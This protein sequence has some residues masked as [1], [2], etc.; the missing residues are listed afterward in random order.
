MRRTGFSQLR[1]LLAIDQTALGSL[2]ARRFAF[3]STAGNNSRA[4]RPMALSLSREAVSPF[5]SPAGGRMR[6]LIE[7]NMPPIATERKTSAASP[8]L[9][10]LAWLI[11]E[12]AWWI[13]TAVAL[14]LLAG[15]IHIVRSE[16]VYAAT[17]TIEVEAEQDKLLKPDA[18]R[19]E[20]RAVALALKNIEQNLQNPALMLRLAQHA[21]LTADPDF[22]AKVQAAG[23][24]GKI[25]RMLADRISVDVRRNTNLMDVTAEGGSPALARNLSRILVEEFVRAASEDRVQVSRQTQDFLRNDADRMKR[26]LEE[27]E[28]RL[29]KYKEQHRAV[30]LEEKQNIVVERLKELNQRVTQARAERLKIEADRA[31][32]AQLADQPPVKLLLL[33][34]IA[35]AP[36]VADLQRRVGEASAELATLA[37]RYKPEHPK[38]I[39]AQSAH[40]ELEAHRDRAILRSAELVG[41]ALE[42]ATVAEQKFEEALRGQESIALQLSEMAIP[43][44]TLARE[45]ESDR[46]LY[47][48]LLARLK[49]TDVA[50]GVSPYA[51]RV[52]SPAALPE[53]PIRPRKAMIL[54]LSLSGGLAAGLAIAFG[55][56]AFDRSLR[57]VDQAEAALGLRSLAAIP[58]QPG[59]ELVEA[60]RLLL[61]K[62]H[63]ALAEAFRGLRTTLLFA[64]GERA[65]RSVL[66]ASAIPREGKSFCAINYAVSLAGYG[67]RTLLVDA[68]LRLPAIGRAF[69]GSASSGT[70]LAEVLAGASPLDAAIHVT[71]IANLSIL[72]AGR[73][74]PDPAKLLG[75]ADLAAFMEQALAR[76]DRVVIDT[77]PVHAVSETMLL[78]PS[79]EVVC[80]VVRAGGPPEHAVLKALE[81]LRAC[82]ASVPGFVL[83]DLPL[84]GGYYYH[85]H[86]PGYGRDEVYG[87]SEARQSR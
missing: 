30:S 26:K 74:V 11:W 84:R 18:A 47:A 37:L 85:Y 53:H 28:S 16:R 75:G 36:E 65:G 71:D 17:T 31:Q 45:V 77:A 38:Y 3:E 39:A 13:A 2:N 14:A 78:V 54:L 58:R 24:E 87:A 82:G 48:S 6:R 41:T 69:L 44:Q 23:S 19:A 8:D 61:E 59:A 80:F 76:F 57:T 66:F 70:G 68:D 52:V 42:A 33:P 4:A 73:I 34:T 21:E 51:V 10:A 64:G 22:R 1:F 56:R 81:K 60:R 79:V 43:Y 72:P 15:T 32:L 20:E 5:F 86:A 67:F 9:R 50:Q 29:Q 49:A 27:S 40:A 7:I 55:S 25:Q 35:A 62:P 63:S 12:K 83:N 46:A